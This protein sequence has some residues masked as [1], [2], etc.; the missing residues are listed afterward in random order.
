MLTAFT[1]ALSIITTAELLDKTFFMAMFLAMQHSRRVAFVAVT[2]ALAAMTVLSVGAGQVVSFLPKEFLNHAEV[3]LFLGFGFKLLY[4]G[5]RMPIKSDCGE[6]LSEAKTVV[7]DSAQK[8]KKAGLWAILL[9]GFILTF[10]AEW[11]DRTQIATISLAV[12][13]NPIGVTAGAILGHAICAAIAVCAGKIICG[14][15]TERTLTLIGG[16]LF[17]GFGILAVFQ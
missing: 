16:C 1:A 17:I 12:N 10:V 8:L 14:R 6:V 15:I 7:D 2:A 5:Y 11:G 4:D 9:E 13:M 3:A